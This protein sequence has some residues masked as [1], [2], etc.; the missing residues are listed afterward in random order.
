ME[1]TSNCVSNCVQSDTSE[2]KV[3]WHFFRNHREK[4]EELPYWEI[5]QI[6]AAYYCHILV[7]LKRFLL[8]LRWWWGVWFFSWEFGPRFKEYP[9]GRFCTGEKKKQSNCNYWGHSDNQYV[10]PTPKWYLFVLRLSVP[11]G[12]G[13]KTTIMKE[14]STSTSKNASSWLYELY[15]LDCSALCGT[16]SFNFWHRGR[17]RFLALICLH[18]CFLGSSSNH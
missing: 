1:L 18:G 3:F 14:A 17:Q 8:C 4:M 12:D 9:T 6:V 2:L 7:E 16:L 13:S 10:V 15:I 11:M 5:D